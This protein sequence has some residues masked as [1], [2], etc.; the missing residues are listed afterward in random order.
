M[1][2]LIWALFHLTCDRVA[3]VVLKPYSSA[4]VHTGVKIGIGNC[5]VTLYA[6][7]IYLLITLY[8]AC[9]TPMRTAHERVFSF[10]PWH[11]TMC[12]WLCSISLYEVVLYM[13]NGKP[14]VFWI[15]HIVVCATSYAAT[16]IQQ[17]LPLYALVSFVEFTGIPLCLVQLLSHNESSAS[18]MCSGIA[19]W[20]SFFILRVVGLPVCLALLV[21]D[22]HELHVTNDEALED[23]SQTAIFVAIFSMSTLWVMSVQWFQTI[24]G[25]MM[26]AVRQLADKKRC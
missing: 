5:A 11:F 19:F 17:F 7:P 13:I 10:S 15:H 9:V 24:H 16:R 22:M 25:R 14:F 26:V 20:G 12:E 6:I 1:R 8:T 4:S 23:V 3:E 21:N 18:Y 2:L